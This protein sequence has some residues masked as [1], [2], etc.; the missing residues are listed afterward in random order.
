MFY[1]FSFVS[2]LVDYLRPLPLKQFLQAGLYISS[3]PINST[4]KLFKNI[5]VLSYDS[6]IL[7]VKAAISYLQNQHTAFNFFTFSANGT[8]SNI[9][10]NGFLSNV[11]SNAA[12]NIIFP[13]LANFSLNVTI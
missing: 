7:L 3:P 10:L 2:N 11:P 1:K 5:N 8:N 6:T 12:I 13:S 4:V 9:L